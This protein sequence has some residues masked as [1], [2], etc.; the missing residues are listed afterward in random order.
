MTERAEMLSSTNITVTGSKGGPGGE[1]GLT[2]GHGGTAEGHQ[3]TL[4]DAS[5]SNFTVNTGL[6]VAPQLASANTSKPKQ[7][8]KLCPLPEPSFVGRQQVLN[9]MNE[10]FNKH[11]GSRCVLVLHG[12]G[13]S[14]KSQLAFR[15]VHKAR[16]RSD[17]YETGLQLLAHK[18]DEWLLLF[19]NANDT[20]VDIAKFF[21]NCSFGNILITTRNQEV[22][23]LGTGIKIGDMD[24]EDAKQLLLNCAGDKAGVK[25]KEELATAIVKELHC[26]TLAVKH[27]GSYIHTRST[28]N[29][30]L[31]LFR[32]SHDRLLREKQI[33][34]QSHYDLSVY[35]TWD[36]SYSKLSLAAKTFLQICSQL[37]YEGITEEIFQ[38]ASIGQEELKDSKV[39]HQVTGLLCLLGKQDKSWDTLI[40]NNVMQELQS[41]SLIT[42]DQQ[43]DSYRIHPLVQLWSN[44]SINELE[45]LQQSVLAIVG[46]SIP[47]G[48]EAEDYIYR[49]KLLHHIS[50]IAQQFDITPSNM[51][52]GVISR[53]TIVLAEEGR[54]HHA[55]KLE[56][57]V[58]EAQKQ[59]L[60]DCDALQTAT[61]LAGIYCQQGRLSE[62]EALQKE[63]LDSI[64]TSMQ[65]E[66]PQFLSSMEQLAE[67][68][69]KQSRWKDA[70]DLYITV[71]QTRKSHLGD[72]SLLQILSSMSALAATYMKQCRWKDAE[73]L[74]TQVLSLLKQFHGELHP[75][76][77]RSKANVAKIYWNQD[78]LEDAEALDAAV[79][80]IREER[81]GAEHLDTVKSKASLALTYWKQNRLDEAKTLQTA[82]VK[83]R[84]SLLGEDHPDTLKSIRHLE[85]TLRSQK[86][87]DEGHNKD[88]KK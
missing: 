57:A 67:I 38:R 23:T 63:A 69:R 72:G 81:L 87:N 83:A 10:C 45:I 34:G 35:T 49:H 22:C 50:D 24:I 62:A 70:E 82:V 20:K 13:G 25:D 74:E 21:P 2:G 68:Y 79:L 44:A 47:L 32:T 40:F 19:D 65:K 85:K 17:T 14:G 53:I 3:F 64:T 29:S 12:L 55:E 80:K 66:G 9:E 31:P 11:R 30:Y 51:D 26:F 71:L 43:D 75:D 48:I 1:G 78:R 76:T 36:L 54:L 18:Q 27:A 16:K 61:I 42:H 84:K 86:Y 7:Q 4:A 77:L 60:G 52:L 56:F 73:N 39:Q 37:H 28:L 46:L 8:R 58:W 59:Q 5:I 88:S 6:Q 33:Q 41:Y 15:Y